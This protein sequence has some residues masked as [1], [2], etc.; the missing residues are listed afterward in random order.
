MS[1]ANRIANHYY[2]NTIDYHFT[3]PDKIPYIEVGA[4]IENIFRLLRIDAVWRLNYQHNPNI[5]KF[6]IKGSIQFKF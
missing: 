1:E 4:G 2:D 3:V 5:V 6:G